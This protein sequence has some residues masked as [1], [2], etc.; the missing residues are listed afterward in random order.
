M[1]GYRLVVLRSG[2]R[3][4]RKA[5]VGSVAD[6][7]GNASLA[8]YTERRSL[9]FT[10]AA[11]A[12]AG[13]G[14][15][16][17]SRRPLQLETEPGI[18]ISSTFDSGNIELVKAGHNS[19]DLCVAFDPFT[20][21]TDKK[22]HAQWFHFRASN[23]RR[24]EES[25]FRLLNAGKC[26]YPPGWIGY[27][28]CC[29]YDR[30]TWVRVPTSYSEKDGVL[31]IK[32]VPS[33]DTA[34]LAYFAPY[35][36]ERHQELVARC[37]QA[38]G[39]SVSSIGKTLDGRDLDLIT[40]GSGRLRVWFQARQ[41]PGESMAEHWI[42]GLLDRLL[43]E[44][45]A[46]GRHLREVCTFFV[47]PNANPDGSVRGYLRTNASGANLNREWAPTGDYDAPTLHR[48]P[49]VVH[50][51]KKMES[52]GGVDFF[53]D[54]HGDEELPHNFFAGTQ[55]LSSWND[56]QAW[57]HQALAEAYQKANPDFGSLLYNYGND[58]RGEADMR[59]ADAQ[60]AH[61][62]GCLAVTL[63]MPFKDCVESPQ[64]EFGWSPARSRRLG[65]SMLDALDAVVADLK[66]DFVVDPA[67]LAPWVQPGYPCP[68][69]E[70]CSWEK[71]H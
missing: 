30:E 29:S 69:S 50:I 47:M 26:S 64:P 63:E 31:T 19:A 32:I 14:V 49:E 15:A 4:Q 41:H 5:L 33:Q 9:S 17:S 45:D 57:L 39:V 56:R 21:G 2:L 12:A 18:S 51:L 44:N 11:A 59:C 60:V 70:E 13:V 68:S 8:R 46:K 42:E 35:S 54:V 22:A 53:C 7:P 20:E 62:F 34:W 66:R 36:Y 37:G 1:H 58:E 3:L 52:I 67:S 55:G 28:A 43:D 61:R 71:K 6:K 25:T 38:A 48:S 16:C 27:R 40:L 24:S 23:L 10:L 65:A